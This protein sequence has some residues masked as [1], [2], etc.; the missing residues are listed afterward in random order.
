MKFDV[1]VGNPPYQSGS[2]QIYTGFYLEMQKV[3]L[4]LFP[5][6]WQEPK[7]A[8]GLSKLNKKEIKED[9]Q[10]VAIKNISGAFPGVSGAEN[11]NIILWKKDY[12]NK[13]NGLQ[14]IIDYDNTVVYKKLL[15]ST[16]EVEKPV[17]IK[18]IVE[19]VKQISNE[20]IIDLIS[21]RMQYGFGS[22]AL[23]NPQK[24]G[25]TLYDTPIP[26]SARLFGRMRS[27]GRTYKYI[28]QALI[29][30]LK[31]TA[32]LNSYKLFLPK[33][34]GN[35][36]EQWLGGS[37][38]DCICAEPGDCCTEMYIEVGPFS[39]ET[40]VKNCCKYFYTKFFRAVFYNKKVSQNTA[41]DTYIEVPIQDFTNNSDIDWSK[42]I[43][44][45][46]RQLYK[47][48]TLT[49]EEIE[50]IEKNIQEKEL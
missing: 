11:T 6:G 33:A 7:N 22:D 17:L 12:D 9:P 32:C 38:S 28:D 14:K 10:I 45:I 29:T 23:D 16:D 48:Y 4:S 40:E 8:N 41:R 3:A 47:K 44:E 50:Y 35:M 37:Y 39:T 36:S 21:T 25:L 42:S 2:Q 30:N 46:D 15:V 49:N 31:E 20:S 19:K 5:V 13:L 43:A 1:C 34:W 18:Q 27:A 24:Y 26:R